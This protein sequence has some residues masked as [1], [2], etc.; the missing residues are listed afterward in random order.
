M[1]GAEAIVVCVCVCFVRHVSRVN[2][3]IFKITTNEIANAC[4]CI[5]PFTCSDISHNGDKD[6]SS[7]ASSDTVTDKKEEKKEKRD[8]EKEK[9]KASP[10]A[11][12]EQREYGQLTSRSITNSVQKPLQ[13]SLL[14][15]EMV[16]ADVLVQALAQRAHYFEVRHFAFLG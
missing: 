6:K 1:D 16:S 8:K 12:A 9:E 15:S 4:V 3:Y 11:V 14:P 7:A 10:A 5:T 2:V 13:L